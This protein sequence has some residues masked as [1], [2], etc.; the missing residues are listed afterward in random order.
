MSSAVE[1]LFQGI[2]SI[3][4]RLITFTLPFIT[5]IILYKLSVGHGVS[6]EPKHTKLLTPFHFPPPAYAI[7][8]FATRAVKSSVFTI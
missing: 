4:A 7:F 3:V 8:K 1:L 6:D 5:P 2:L